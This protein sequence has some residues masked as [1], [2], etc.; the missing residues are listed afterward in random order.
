MGALITKY[1]KRITLYKGVLTVYVS[2][3]P[4]RQE[5]NFK[6]ENIKEMFNTALGEELV[7]QVKIS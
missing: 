3:S 7:Q 4:L 5:L 1:T 6:K 2:S